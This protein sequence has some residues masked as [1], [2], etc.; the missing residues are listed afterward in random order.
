MAKRAE[1]AV[2]KAL[3]KA[4]LENSRQLGKVY[5]LDPEMAKKPKEIV[6]LEGAANEGAVGNI[7]CALRAILDGVIPNSP[8]VSR[9]AAGNLRSLA[10]ENPGF[11][12]AVLEHVNEVLF[13]LQERAASK[14]FMEVETEE[15]LKESE[16]LTKLV[17][18]RG[19]VY[20][21]SLPHYLNYPCKEDPDRF[22][23]KV[24]RTS[25]NFVDRVVDSHR[26]TGLPE[27]PI[28][29]RTYFSGTMDPKEMEGKFHLMLK[30]SGLQT[31]ARYAGV[32]WFATTEDQLD[33]IAELLG[34][35][36]SR[37][38]ESEEQ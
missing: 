20:A 13:E 24:G 2:R 21:Y 23:F 19:G 4:L 38:H 17:E 10:K 5:F 28:I 9:Q 14:I 29:R 35:E 34:L 37:P 27:D 25:G 16:D 30:A 36:I 15:R 18:K 1:G 32:E 3:I 22:W 31:D 11:E 6:E 8:A 7:R 26:K 33:A 12:S